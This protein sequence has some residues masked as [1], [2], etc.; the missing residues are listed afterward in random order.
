MGYVR[1]TALFLINAALLEPSRLQRL[2]LPACCK[3][4]VQ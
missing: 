4:N 1:P 2:W 3:P